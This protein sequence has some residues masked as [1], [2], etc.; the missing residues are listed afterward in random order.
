[1]STV[2]SPRVRQEDVRALK[3]WGHQFLNSNSVTRNVI[4]ETK[5]NPYTQYGQKSCH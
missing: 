4:V 1:M 3:M 5:W 2:N